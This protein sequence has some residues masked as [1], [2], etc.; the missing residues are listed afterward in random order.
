M[1]LFIVTLLAFV[2]SLATYLAHLIMY[3]S[4]RHIE[5]RGGYAKLDTLSKIS[6][7]TLPS[8]DFKFSHFNKTKE[9]FTTEF[10]AL[11]IQLD[12]VYYWLDPIMLFL[13]TIY[14]N[15]KWIKS[16]KVEWHK[17]FIVGDDN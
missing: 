6:N 8:K 13:F 11:L 5:V 3:Y 12:G 9:G 17:Y 15:I 1:I 7:K 16:E 14:M 2:I 10:H 4:D